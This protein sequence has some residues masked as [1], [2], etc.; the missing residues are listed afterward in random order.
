MGRR[1]EQANVPSSSSP[2]LVKS[3]AWSTAE[4]RS[5]PCENSEMTDLFRKL[6]LEK[7]TE[8]FQQ[9]EVCMT[10]FQRIFGMLLVICIGVLLSQIDL[11]TFLTLDDQDLKELGINTFGA[12]RKMLLAIAGRC[13]LSY[14]M[15]TIIKSANRHSP[16][17]STVTILEYNDSIQ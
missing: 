17:H 1:D 8:L 14:S 9:Q 7:Y 3:A 12:R 13:P 5:S 16:I 15:V 4:S 10:P 6:G 11:A 2:Q